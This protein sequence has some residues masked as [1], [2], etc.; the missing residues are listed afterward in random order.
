MDRQLLKAVALDM[1]QDVDF[2]KQSLCEK[3]SFFIS[4]RYLLWKADKEGQ[5]N[6]HSLDHNSG[7]QN[8]T[9][10]IGSSHFLAWILVR[11]MAFFP[12]PCVP[13]LAQLLGLECLAGCTGLQSIVRG[14]THLAWWLGCSLNPYLLSSAHPSR[15][16][17]LHIHATLTQPTT[18]HRAYRL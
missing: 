14:E 13:E 2:S 10:H 5:K 12:S 7:T 11:N 1:Q 9:T 16:T 17:S 8:V 18:R 3:E 6:V 4:K 15:S